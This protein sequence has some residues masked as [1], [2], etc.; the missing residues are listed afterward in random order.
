MVRES[1]TMTVLTPEVMS[2]ILVL[3]W[4]SSH[5]IHSILLFSHSEFRIA[6]TREFEFLSYVHSTL[7]S[8]RNRPLSISFF[9][10]NEK[11]KKNLKVITCDISFKTFQEDLIKTFK[12]ASINV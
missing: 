9:D 12:T 6:I 3:I 10:L 5:N 7:R 1:E 11:H 4:Y 8:T 2:P